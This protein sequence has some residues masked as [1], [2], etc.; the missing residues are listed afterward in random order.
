M[1]KKAN[2]KAL[3]LEKEVKPFFLG[4]ISKFV[5]LTRRFP[6]LTSKFVGL[7]T[8]AARTISVRAALLHHTQ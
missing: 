4:L 7:K 1:G 8:S 6:G 2:E 5:G 3:Y